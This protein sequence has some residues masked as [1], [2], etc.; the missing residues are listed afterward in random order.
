MLPRAESQRADAM[1]APNRFRSFLPLALFSVMAARHALSQQ[2]G[3]ANSGASPAR[4]L[5]T[6][7]AITGTSISLTTDSGSEVDAQIQSTAVL[8]KT[9]PGRKDLQGATPIQLEDIQPGDRMLL[10]GKLADDGK[11][12]LATSGVVMKRQDIAQK[13]E[14]EREDWNKRGI[15][16]VVTSVDPSGGVIAI[17]T[18]SIAAKTVSVHLSKTT[19]LRRYATDSVKF[20]DAKP[21]P[22]DQ[23]KPGDQLRARGSRG[24]DGG[25]FAADEVVSGTFRNIAGTLIT[26]NPAD[27]TVTVTD[28]LSKRPI[29]VRVGGDSQLRKLPAMV[30]EGIAA[31]LKSTPSGGTAGAGASG[32]APGTSPSPA[33]SSRPDS[34]PS[35]PPGN[36]AG[37]RSGGPPDFQQMLS[38]MPPVTISELQKG[39]AV[40][41]VATEGGAATAPTA[42]TLLTGVEAILSASPKDN[43]AAMTL[44]PWS[45]SAPAGDAGP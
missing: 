11:S 7:K 1:I 23:I 26:A 22:V 5:G 27:H 6:V 33:D 28:L 39:D 43:R 42:I 31:R 18:G 17:S 29:T 40:I 35:G 30:A 41:I 34:S 13:Q 21:A 15:G 44:S 37:F 20:D 9:A 16:G 2:G 4:S 3:P 10:R 12:I 38:R 19:I 25:D 8:V 45:L 36:G 32:S 24:A 14:Q